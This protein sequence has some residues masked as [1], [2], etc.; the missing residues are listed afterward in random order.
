M[1]KCVIFTLYATR[2]MRQCGFVLLCS[3]NNRFV[4]KALFKHK[5]GDLKQWP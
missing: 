4:L 2:S 3:V 1:W 5:E